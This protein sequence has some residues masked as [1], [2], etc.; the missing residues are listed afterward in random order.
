LR[1]STLP[2]SEKASNMIRIL[3]TID[4]IDAVLFI[5]IA[6][7]ALAGLNRG[8]L[9]Q[10]M[11]LLGII[12]GI[13]VAFL[14][15]GTVVRVLSTYV[16]YPTLAAVLSFML[17]TLSVWGAF[18]LLAGI[19]TEGLRSAGL[20]WANHLVGM[21][22]GLMIG[23][24]LAACLLLLLARLPGLVPH[25]LIAKSKLAPLIFQILQPLRQ[26]LPGNI[27]LFQAI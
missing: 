16:P 21:L 8:F 18:M 19:A 22:I 2:S 13:Y 23:A 24:F 7:E 6:C 14:F 17:I 5:V 3:N 27:S 11:A 26:F 9:R 10:T 25:T 12:A 15:Y 20:D 4:P 1:Y